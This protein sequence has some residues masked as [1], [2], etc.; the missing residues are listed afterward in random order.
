MTDTRVYEAIVKN[1]TDA[2][3]VTDFEGNIT[4][5]NQS[6]EDI[7]GYSEGEVLGKYVHDVLPVHELRERAD[8]AFRKFQVNR[9][10]GPLIGK[11]IHVK[12]L[13]KQ[14]KP[15]HVHFSP[16]VIELNGETII[17]VFIRDITE[18]IELQE[19]LRVQSTTDELT[20]VFNR[21][22]FLDNFKKAF[23][24]AQRKSLP[25]SLLL[26]DID[27]FKKV[28]DQFGH[29]T[30]DLV[31]KLFAQSVSGMIRDEDIFGRVGGEEF[32]L[33]LPATSALDALEIA[34]RIRKA[35]ELLEIP[36]NSTNLRITTS[37]G[38]T[39]ATAN[40]TTAK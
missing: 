33:A 29:Q 35:I 36:T 39:S 38:L 7:F 18:I 23:N 22:A 8:T 24:L 34:E 40:D 25:L 32:Y 16:N 1:A 4:L 20:G 27:F 11:G 19:K 5:W 12:G 2:V 26:F 13:T 9:G 10:H 31:I 17:Y 28:N 30:G 14:G 37:I 3:I 6:A 15:I 21:R